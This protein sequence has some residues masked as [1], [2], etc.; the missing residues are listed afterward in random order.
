MMPVWRN[1]P[2]IPPSKTDVAS[3]LI[4]MVRNTDG[5]YLGTLSECPRM[6]CARRLILGRG[7]VAH[8]SSLV[9]V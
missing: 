7:A 5:A 4:N 6:T 3:S 1:K 2:M 8:K 9:D